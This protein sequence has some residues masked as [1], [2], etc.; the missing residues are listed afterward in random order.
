[1]KLKRLYQTMKLWTI[2]G[3]AKRAEWAKQQNIYAGMGEK[4]RIMDRKIP[5]YAKLIYFH[6]NIQVA[7]KVDFITHD[8]IHSVIN[9]FFEGGGGYRRI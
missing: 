5:L 3:D 4:V 7:S 8:V 1:M 2:S 6:N 9:E